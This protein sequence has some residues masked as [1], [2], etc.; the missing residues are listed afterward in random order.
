MLWFDNNSYAILY[1][2]DF[3]LLFCRS[4]FLNRNC[5]FAFN[6][7]SKIQLLTIP[8]RITANAQIKPNHKT[9]MN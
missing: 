1:F 4:A 3:D 6:N 9:I 2:D 8:Q 5:F 7:K